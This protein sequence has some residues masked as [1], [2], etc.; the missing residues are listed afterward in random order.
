MALKS[1][2]KFGIFFCQNQFSTFFLL[3][4]SSRERAFFAASLRRK[5]VKIVLKYI[6]Q[7]FHELKFLLK[8]REK[9]NIFLQSNK[10]KFQSFVN[11][12]QI[13]PI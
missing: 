12:F 3:P 5:S 10:I 6:Y 1:K 2:K 7:L 8:T 9:T 11:I 4:L 13:S